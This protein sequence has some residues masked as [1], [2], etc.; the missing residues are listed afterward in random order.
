MLLFLFSGGDLSRLA[1]LGKHVSFTARENWIE[2]SGEAVRTAKAVWPS[3][4]SR[5][6]RH[7]GQHDQSHR[8][9]R[10]RFV[11][12]MLNLVAHPGLAVE[13]QVDESEHVERS[14]QGGGVP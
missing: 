12:V 11:D 2:V 3:Q 13:R 7:H 5:K 14:H 6:E 9:R 4:K 10:R 1:F 8:H